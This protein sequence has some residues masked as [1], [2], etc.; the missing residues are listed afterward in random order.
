[1]CKVV[2]MCGA[3][4]VRALCC[5]TQGRKRLRTLKGSQFART[6]G[7]YPLSAVQN[8]AVAVDGLQKRYG[9]FCLD[10]PSL[11]IGRGE[12]AG[13]I[14][15]NGAGKSTFIKLVLGLISKDSGSIRVNNRDKVDENLKKKIGVVFDQCCFTGIMTAAQLN[16]MFSGVYGDDWDEEKYLSLIDHFKLPFD[17]KIVEFSQGMKAKLSIISA[18][19][20]SPDLLIL[21]EATS[22]LDPVVRHEIND[23]LGSYVKKSG[24]TVLFSSHLVNELE[25]LCDRIL[26]MSGGQIV[27]QTCPKELENEFYVM[28]TDRKTEIPQGVFSCLKKDD[29]NHCLFKGLPDKVPA[30]AT[31]SEGIS[32]DDLL[33]YIEKGVTADGKPVKGG[34]RK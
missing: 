10:I 12:F 4:G 34:L 3:A 29:G 30:G 31:M 5:A 21:D 14:G 17:K 7:G 18:L 25:Q 28:K 2:P 23:V 33:F 27:M 8:L 20:H 9:D 32:A 19:S 11:N 24:C 1:M 13:L 22:A 16:K 6:A 15:E 26:I